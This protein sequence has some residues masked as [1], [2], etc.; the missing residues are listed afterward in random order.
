MVVEWLGVGKGG[1]ERCSRA[2]RTTGAH[3]GAR[4]V[5]WGRDSECPRCRLG[6][7]TV[8]AGARGEGRESIG[9]RVRLPHAKNQYG[10]SLYNIKASLVCSGEHSLSVPVAVAY[11]TT[12]DDYPDPLMKRWKL[13]LFNESTPEQTL[14]RVLLPH[15]EHQVPTSG[16]QV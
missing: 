2:S 10:R 12:G 13:K 8:A 11:L 15:S 6:T 3:P 7:R 1:L 16:D 5:G 9:C 4:T 14:L